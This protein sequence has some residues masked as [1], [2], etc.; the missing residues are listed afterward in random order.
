MAIIGN[1]PYFQ[2]NPFVVFLTLCWESARDLCQIYPIIS[3]IT[4]YKHVQ[5][6]PTSGIVPV[7]QLQMGSG[8]CTKP[9]CVVC[10]QFTMKIDCVLGRAARLLN[11]KEPA[12][13]Q[14]G[15]HGCCTD[16]NRYLHLSSS[17]KNRYYTCPV[18]HVC[19]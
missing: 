15:C 11:L 4:V 1:I 7:Q 5:H 16:K 14:A 8:F 17:D 9:V 10:T 12:H 19:T 6:A 13:K 3:N 18:A 2:T